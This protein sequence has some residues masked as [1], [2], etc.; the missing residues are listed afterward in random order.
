MLK[1]ETRD[2]SDKER[3]QLQ[4]SLAGF[5]KESIGVG[6]SVFVFATLVGILPFVLIDRLEEWIG[7]YE[8]LYVSAVI[9]VAA[10]LGLRIVQQTLSLDYPERG[11]LQ[12]VRVEV[13]R[14]STSRAIQREDPEDFG[15]SFY[16]DVELDG[17][18]KTIFLWGQYLDLLDYEGQFPNTEFILIRRS[19]TKEVMDLQVKGR[20]FPP[21]R[22]LPFF[23]DSEWRNGTIP[24]DGQILDLCID[25]VD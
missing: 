6:I 18:C 4:R 13:L 20:Y 24:Q 1:I 11:P 14:V 19:D 7:E 16:I 10:I 2:L 12:D 5:W 3:K 23:P 25:E 15:I 9:V 21:E 22:V 8:G 17:E